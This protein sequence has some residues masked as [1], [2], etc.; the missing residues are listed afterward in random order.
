MRILCHL[1]GY[2]EDD[3]CKLF[4]AKPIKR[5]EIHEIVTYKKLDEHF[6][7]FNRGD[8]GKVAETFQEFEIVDQRAA[9]PLGVPLTLKEGRVLRDEQMETANTWLSKGYGI[10]KAPT[11]WG[12]TVLW[13]YLVQHIGLKTLL[14]AQETRHLQVGWE[15]LYEHTN[16]AELEAELGIQI[17]GRLGYEHT[18]QAD[19]TVKYKKSKDPYKT[20]PITFSTFQGLSSKKGKEAL[21]HVK[22]EFGLVWLEEAHHESAETFHEVTKSFNSWYKGGQSATPTRKDQTHVATYDTIGPITAVATKEQMSCLYTFISTGVVVPNWIFRGQYPLPKLFT[23]LA[24]HEDVQNIILQWM[25]YDIQSGRKPLY[26]TERK[27]DAFSMRQNIHMSGYN[28]ELIMG[29]PKT[30]TKKQS[31]YSQELLDE[32]LHAII[33]TKVIKENYNIPPLDTIHLLYPNFGVET[34]EQMT[35]RI[36]RYVLDSEGNEIFK[37]RP[38]IRVYTFEADNTLPDKSMNFR[39]NFYR[40]MGFEELKLDDTNCNQKEA[41]K[42]ETITSKLKDW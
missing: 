26:I 42:I 21:A 16:I 12:K 2:K 14:L 40:K 10:V 38:L 13:C 39:K 5:V 41:E 4:D 22:N 20:Y 32:K 36:R 1:R 24:K 37:N 18:I 30:V 15:G 3:Y 23:Y 9:V 29:G 11:G 7:I 33:G 6:Y 19:G 25:L 27:L 35:G 17:C 28:V 34:E 31:T 8:L